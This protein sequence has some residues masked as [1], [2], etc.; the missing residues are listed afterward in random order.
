MSLDCPPLNQTCAHEQ[1]GPPPTTLACA[2]AW[3]IQTSAEYP[4]YCERDGLRL[5]P[6]DDVLA[7]EPADFT[8]LMTELRRATSAAG[9]LLT[10]AMRATGRAVDP[11]AGVTNGYSYEIEKLHPLV[12]WFNLMRLVCLARNCRHTIKGFHRVRVCHSPR[13]C[14]FLLARIRTSML[15]CL[16]SR[17]S[18][19]V[20]AFCI[21]ARQLQHFTHT[22]AR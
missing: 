22:R 7:R 6:S 4:G 13:L 15:V 10:A 1:V 2:A 19:H 8:A 16:C 20:R 21:Y 9:L 17:N 18:T 14:A 3:H 12:D 5:C 11:A